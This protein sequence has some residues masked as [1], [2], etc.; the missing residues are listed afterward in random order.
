MDYMYALKHRVAIMFA[1]LKVKELSGHILTI[2][3][4]LQKRKKKVYACKLLNKTFK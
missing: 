1:F 2:L 4:T 3:S